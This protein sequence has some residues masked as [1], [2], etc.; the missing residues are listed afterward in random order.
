M[1]YSRNERDA[2][3]LIDKAAKTFG[4]RLP[5]AQ[6]LGGKGLNTKCPKCY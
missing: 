4:S 2:I 6:A 5:V 3:L 1:S